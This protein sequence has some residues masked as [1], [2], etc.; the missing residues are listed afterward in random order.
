MENQENLK[1]AVNDLY[2]FYRLIVAKDFAENLSAPHLKDLSKELMRMYRGDYRRLCVALPPRHGKS[3]MITLSFPL[4]L[5][6]H[7]PN[8]NI[9]VINNSSE[10]SMKFGLELREMFHRYGK[11]FNVY[12][13]KLKQS[14]TFFKFCDS[15]DNLYNGSIRLV[16]AGGSITGHDADYIIV[17]DPYKGL[18][19]ELTPTALQKK[20]DWFDI[21]VEQRV[22]PQTRL[23]VL[24][25]RWHSYD[26]IGELKK[27]RFD[28]YKFVEYPAILDD[29]TP[30]WKE[31]YSIEELEKKREVMGYR[32]FESIYQQKPLDDDT[33]FFDLGNIRWYNPQKEI[34]ATV[35]GWDIASADESEHKN[36]FTSGVKMHLLT[37]GDILVSDLVYGKFGTGTKDV[38]L[39]TAVT[40]GMDTHIIIETGVAGAGKLLYKEWSDQLKPYIVEQALPVT[41]KVDRAT[42]FQNA[43]ADKKV[44]IDIKDKEKL[45]ALKNELNSFPSG[46]H[47][48][49]CDSLSHSYNW[50]CKQDKGSKPDLI[51]IDL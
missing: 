36:D 42:P 4:W 44:Y 31:R 19:E 37:D 9:L 18:A 32:M 43:V 11:Y 39:R 3:S 5:I 12:L 35:R 7:N 22:E 34:L 46:I 21:I 45:K 49:I 51:F 48:D 15:E 41:S 28:D 13:S 25:T 47:D 20:I 50:L 24:H 29:G 16:G 30:L 23:V 10:L 38:I 8:L 1:K 17:D 33:D 27:T 26:I 14:Q 6:F 40:D 2:V